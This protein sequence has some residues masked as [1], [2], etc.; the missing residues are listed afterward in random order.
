MT[1]SRHLLRRSPKRLD[2]GGGKRLP[3]EG[4]GRS[5]ACQMRT[6]GGEHCDVNIKVD[7]DARL[8]RAVFSPRGR[9]WALEA[10]AILRS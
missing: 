5:R 4:Q 3:I 8:V 6:D 2:G 9:S 10:G 1:S 7:V